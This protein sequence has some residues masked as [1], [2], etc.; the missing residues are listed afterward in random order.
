M[1]RLSSEKYL[2]AAA[3]SAACVAFAVGYV[4]HFD[5]GFS[6]GEIR[7]GALGGAAA[8]AAFLFAGA[9]GRSRDR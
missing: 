1:W 2:L 8:I 6:T 9:A 7:T 5:F 4:A 3:V